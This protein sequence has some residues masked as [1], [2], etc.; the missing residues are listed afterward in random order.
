MLP[1]H[2]Y[3][4]FGNYK[5]GRYLSLRWNPG[6]LAWRLY[7]YGK[8]WGFRRQGMRQAV[9]D[10]KQ[11]LRVIIEIL[12]YRFVVPSANDVIQLPVSGDLCLKVR[13]GYKI[14]DLRRQK[15]VKMFSPDVDLAKVRN[16]I[17]RVRW[18][19]THSFAP[20]VTRWNVDERWYE[21]DYVNGYPATRSNWPVF[22]HAF[23]VSVAPL[24]VHMILAASPREVSSMEYIEGRTEIVQGGQSRLADT[25]LDATKVEKV[26]SFVE[27][28][29]DRLKPAGERP[30][31][32]VYSHG[33][34]S[35]GH[36]LKTRHEAVI[37]DWEI[38]GYRS[39]LYDLYDFFFE[40]LWQGYVAPGMAVAMPKAISQVQSLLA[41]N[42]SAHSS[43]LSLLP[44]AEVYRWVYYIERV[45]KAVERQK[46]TDAILDSS[47]LR[48]IDAFDSYEE[49]LLNSASWS[50]QDY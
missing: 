35:P 31:S 22:L 43:L 32:L 42:T 48:M 3:V 26:R 1:Q 50:F 23:Q 4:R 11:L 30:I 20:N 28:I 44:A 45:C 37:I 25:R 16:E 17:D 36:V 8:P 21:E 14:F 7:W 38:L 39:A 2:Q 46:M 19:G 40:R 13:N 29:I 12:Y 49:S 24:V 10:G 34:F 27:G 41:L 9:R 18:V 5:K 6:L 15:V 33:D 47:I